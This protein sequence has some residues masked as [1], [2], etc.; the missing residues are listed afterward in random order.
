[1]PILLFESPFE[2]ASGCWHHGSRQRN[3]SRSWGPRTART[4][5]RALDE[6]HGH[7]PDDAP[8]QA[9]GTQYFAMDVDD[10]PAAG[11]SR[12]DRLSE[13]RPQERAQRR[14][15]QQIVDPVPLPTLDDRAPQMVGQLLNLA[16]FLDT[17]LPDPEQ[18]IEVPKI[19]SDDVPMRALVRETQLAEQLVEVPTIVSWSLL[20]QIME[21][22]VGNPVPHDGRGASGGLQGFL[23]GHSS[24]K[25]TANKIADLPAPR[26][27]VRRLQGYLPEQSSTA[28]S[29]S[30]PERISERIVEQNVE[31]PVFGGLQDFLP[32][33][34][35][36]AASSSPAGVRGFADVPG[37]GVFR[38]F[39]Q[40][41]K[42]AKF[43]G[44]T[45]EN[46]HAES[47]PSTPAAHVDALSGVELLAKIQQLSDQVVDMG[48][49]AD[50]VREGFTNDILMLGRLIT[51]A[52]HRL[53]H[54]EVWADEVAGDDEDPR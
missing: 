11:G 8:P 49:R 28:T 34:S 16:H 12:P 17:P 38:T 15:V 36:S 44:Q 43:L 31:F 3:G 54:L 25:R 10:V 23:P 41:Q 5:G 51:A 48:R 35:S 42:S 6:L 29:S 21:Q 45:S 26:S 52:E 30:S 18:V 32:G 33:Q 37:E 24:S 39:P 9:A 40:I 46:L 20:Q 2:T 4:G 13:V 53:E 22:N 14:T 7:A 50:H 27:G 1:M 47:S 19:L